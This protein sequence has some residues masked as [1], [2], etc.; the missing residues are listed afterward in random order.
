MARIKTIYPGVFQEIKISKKL[1]K[2]DTFFYIRFYD[3]E[4]HEHFEKVQGSKLT[5]GLTAAK[6]NQ[7]RT[8]KMTGQIPT[9]KDKRAKEKEIKEQE[10]SRWTLDRLWEMY[11]ANGQAAKS[12]RSDIYQ[13]RNHLQPVFGDKCPHEL[14]T[15]DFDKLRMGMSEKYAP[16]TVKHIIAMAKRI[17]NYGAKKG[18]CDKFTF[19]IEMPFV[20]NQKTEDLS[21]EQQ[22]KLWEILE[23]DPD[24]QAANFMK[25]ILFTGMRRGELFK[26]TW[27]DI[28]WSN[29]FILLRDPKGVVNSKIPMSPACREMLVT[30]ER[31][32]PQSPYVFAGKKG[33]KRV[34]I[35]KPTNRIC[36]EA[37]IPNGFR[38]NHGLR[39]VFASNLANSGEVDLYTLQKLMTHKDQRMTQRYAHLRDDSLKAAASVTDKL[40]KKFKK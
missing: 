16:Q 38:A 13:Y 17:V 4:G 33:G 32:H 34:E 7:V 9:N 40:L 20:D 24:R 14:T 11:Q 35:R 22:A 37:G 28:D 15:W 3:S 10:N 39:H 29:G 2:E 26:L 8:Q 23:N 18:I 31:P 25:M 19:H 5:T 21:P 27:G 6:A 12:R 30:H 1:R 36:K